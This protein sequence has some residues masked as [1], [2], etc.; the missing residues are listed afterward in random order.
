MNGKV[1]SLH[2]VLA[3]ITLAGIAFVGRSCVSAHAA[4]HGRISATEIVR[5]AER[6]G[7]I[8]VP[9]TGVIY[10]NVEGR[11]LWRQ[12]RV[13]GMIW[14]A[15]S[16]DA[17]G[18]DLAYTVWDAETGEPLLA[19]IQARQAD[20]GEPIARRS[21]L[22]EAGYWLRQLEPGRSAARWKLNGTAEALGDIWRV[23]CRSADRQ[24]IITIDRSSGDL[25]TAA[26]RRG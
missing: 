1:S 8:A 18:D 13:V 24:A 16:T 22:R 6:L 26:I 9:K 12:S 17:R 7:R 19:S 5:S 21:A 23:P 20:T 3:A 4:R 10:T 2:I 11:C 25:I 15:Q 14:C